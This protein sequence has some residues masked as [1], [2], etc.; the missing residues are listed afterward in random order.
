MS[1]KVNRFNKRNFNE[2]MLELANNVDF[3]FEVAKYSKGSLKLEEIMPTKDFRNW[4]KK[5]LITCGMDKK[6]ASKVLKNDF[7]IETMNGLYNFF[8]AAV[9]TYMSQGNKFD[10]IPTKDF[11]GSIY[12]NKVP[13]KK[14]TTKYYSPKDRSYLGEFETTTGD[15]VK[16]KSSSECP[17]YL[18]SRK[19]I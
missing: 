9:Y 16:L 8:A 7:T 19:R 2:L 1:E 18:Q 4:C 15:Y 14:K 17:K 13:K 10:M 3:K 11:K 12:L 6:E 5:L